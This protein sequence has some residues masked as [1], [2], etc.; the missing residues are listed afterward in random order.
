MLV[1]GI[2]NAYR[3]DDGVG[4]AVARALHAKDL[5]G[6]RCKEDP[7]DTLSLIEQW[8]TADTVILIDAVSSG[9]E[10]GTIYR[11][12]ALAQPIPT[13]VSLRSTHSLGLAEALS[14]AAVLH[15]LPSRLLV[16]GIEGKHFGTGVRLSPQVEDAMKTIIEQV[17]HECL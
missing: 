5:P 9:A 10:P 2:G 8:D 7:G 15:R 17:E 12:D 4:P 6:V 3:S 16:Y 11:F 14:I 1:I 13:N